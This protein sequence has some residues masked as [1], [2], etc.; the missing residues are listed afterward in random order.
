MALRFPPKGLIRSPVYY[1]SPTKPKFRFKE[2]MAA[3]WSFNHSAIYRN[4]HLC[5]AKAN[6]L[7]LAIGLTRVNQK[8]SLMQ[9]RHPFNSYNLMHMQD[10]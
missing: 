2:P 6:D 5:L 1:I 8:V 7:S 4:L 9:L 3:T 10:S